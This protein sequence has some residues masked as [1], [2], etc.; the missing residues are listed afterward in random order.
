MSSQR[1]TT[2][3]PFDEETWAQLPSFFDQLPQPV[4]LHLWGDETA[5]QGERET[6]V[7]CRALADRF[8]KIEF[9]AFPRRVNYPY[10]P[11]IGV[12]GSREAESEAAPATRPEAE[13][14]DYGVRLI[15]W[16]RGYQLTS[17]ITAIQVVAFKGMT[18]EPVTRIRLHKLASEVGIEVLTTADDEAGALM[19]KIAFGLAVASPHVRAYLIMADQFPEAVIRYSVN[20]VPHTVINSRVHLEGVVGEEVVMRH[21]AQAVKSGGWRK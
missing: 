2:H 13:P 20:R 1:F 11:V 3:H 17:L 6:A 16:P 5:S 4:R 7:L 21:L 9:A 10:Y 15:G 12:M 8:D 18:L 14:V 19:G